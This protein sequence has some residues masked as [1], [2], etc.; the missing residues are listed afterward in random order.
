METIAKW[1]DND[2]MFLLIHG[3]IGVGKTYVLEDTLKK[4]NYQ[5]I[6][7]DIETK[8]NYINLKKKL[9]ESY[10]FQYFSKLVIIFDNAHQYFIDKND[11][12]FLNHDFPKM[13]FVFVLSTSDRSLL[14]KKI[15]IPFESVEILPPSA[16]HLK[17][18]YK[19]NC[20]ISKIKK[21]MRM[22]NNDIRQLLFQLNYN[23]STTKDVQLTNIYKLMENIFTKDI[24]HTQ[25]LNN[26]DIFIMPTMMHENY[27]YCRSVDYIK[28]SYDICIG[29]LMHT[30]MYKNTLW[31]FSPFVIYISL[32][33]PMQY[34]KPTNIEVKYG[35][36]LSKMMNCQTRKKTF[37]NACN[38]Y[39][40]NTYLEL[41]ALTKAGYY[42]NDNKYVKLKRKEIVQIEKVVDF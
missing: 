13:K 5:Y 24:S 26:S 19:I 18:F 10:G 32:V 20:T 16:Q 37:K 41:H 11:I 9:S 36:I 30:Y 22:N 35:S 8:T 14:T 38:T 12:N 3:N 28:L 23:V 29:D 34:Y 17:N 25:I 40:V 27:I 33:S 42:Y 4:T 1:L 39:N 2:V 31:E 6:V 21:L 15:S 7:H